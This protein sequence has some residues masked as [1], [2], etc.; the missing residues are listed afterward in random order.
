M[1]QGC[2]WSQAC[3]SV[4]LTCS[5]RIAPPMTRSANTLFASRRTLSAA[6]GTPEEN[7]APAPSRRIGRASFCTR[8]SEE[9]V[10]TESRCAMSGEPRM[11]YCPAFEPVHSLT[12]WNLRCQGETH[13]ILGP[14]MFSG[15]ILWRIHAADYI[16]KF[17]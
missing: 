10:W 6:S 9:R 12:P 13:N 5:G 2:D 7:E 11:S 17:V 3:H 1:N 15:R 4:S 16:T 14:H 8:K